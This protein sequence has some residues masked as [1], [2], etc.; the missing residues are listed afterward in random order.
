MAGTLAVLIALT[1]I[2]VLLAGRS[3]T[4]GH[5]NDTGG[6]GMTAL[7]QTFPFT[8]CGFGVATRDVTPP[9]GI[10]SRSW[11]GQ[12]HDVAEGFTDRSP[13]RP[14]C[15]RRSPGRAELALVA[16][17]IRLVPVRARRPC[18]S[19]GWSSAHR[20]RTRRRS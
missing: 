8:H 11:C 12:S 13:R 15:S 6:R 14:R 2:A 5:T 9:V 16:L 18:A 10:Y 7:E 19:R 20:A 1:G 3:Q 17:D 4:G